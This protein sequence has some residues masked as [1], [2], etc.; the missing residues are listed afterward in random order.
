MFLSL[1]RIHHALRTGEF[2]SYI[3]AIFEE[4]GFPCSVRRSEY[5]DP[6]N[7][8][9]KECEECSHIYLNRAYPKRYSVLCRCKDEHGK[10]PF[11]MVVRGYLSAKT[12]GMDIVESIAGRCEIP[13]IDPRFK[14]KVLTGA[15]LVKSGIHCHKRYDSLVRRHLPVHTTQEAM[16]MHKKGRIPFTDIIRFLEDKYDTI[17]RDASLRCR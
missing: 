11:K 7:K 5:Y 14:Q 13:Q 6:N 1:S 17:I 9:G 3:R 12:A 8:D 2:K 15:L 16:L 10:C 4:H